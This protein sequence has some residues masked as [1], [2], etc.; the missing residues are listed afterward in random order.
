MPNKTTKYQAEQK[1]VCFCFILAK[2][3]ILS[4]VALGGILPC[5]MEALFCVFSLIFDISWICF[6]LFFY[7]L[8]L[9]DGF[10]LC[11]SWRLVIYRKKA[12]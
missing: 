1:F 9:A 11:A 3:G 7:F 12:C 8:K 2:R 10:V 5:G 4:A 6:V